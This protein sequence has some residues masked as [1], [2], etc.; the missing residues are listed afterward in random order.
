MITIKDPA[1]CCGCSACAAVCPAT[2]ITMQPNE[3]GFLQPL[4]N[5]NI[6]LACGACERVCPMLHPPAARPNPTAF[7]VVNHDD[8]VRVQSSS[9]GVFSLLA[10]RILEAGGAVCGVVYG[11][12]FA[13]SHAL[14][15]TAVGVQEMRGAK[16]VQSDKNTTFRR[17]RT[18]LMDNHPVLFTGTPCEVA[19]LQNYLGSDHPCLLTADVICHGVP[20]PL[21]WQRMIAERGDITE[22]N[23]RDKRDGWRN[24]NI[25]FQTEEGEITMPVMESAYMR[26]FLQDVTVRQSCAVCPAKGNSRRADLT[27]GDFWGVEKIEGAPDDNKGTS[28]VLVHTEKGQAALSALADETQGMQVNLADALRYNPSATTCATL[29]AGYDAFFDALRAGDKTVLELCEQY[30]PFVQESMTEKI[31]RK[32]KR[33]I[34]NA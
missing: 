30:A 25:T 6:C 12:G 15:N 10:Q 22:V 34:R 28:L 5:E 4:V 7:A 19:G 13:V 3:N 2:C 33:F 24:Y 31:K 17:I 27:L 1:A 18:L 32:L 11:E 14:T 8:S 21:V 9:G 23:L 16:Y 26:A 29:S 20:S